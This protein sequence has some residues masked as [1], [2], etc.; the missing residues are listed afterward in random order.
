MQPQSEKV[1]LDKISSPGAL[2]SANEF[3][4]DKL[5]RF[6]SPAIVYPLVRALFPVRT[7]FI[8]DITQ[9][10]IFHFTRVESSP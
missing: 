4:N 7:A 6:T 5:S 1:F 8:N 2:K 9:S 10:W 3:R